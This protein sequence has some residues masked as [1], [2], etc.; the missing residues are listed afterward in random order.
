M[1]SPNAVSIEKLAQLRGVSRRSAYTA[2]SK[3]D[4]EPIEGSNLYDLDNPKNARWIEKRPHAGRAKDSSASD[5]RLS[6]EDQKLKADIALK[7]RQARKLDRQ[8]EVDMQRLIPS[9]IAAAWLGAY[10][11]GTRIHLLDL[12]GRLAPRLH[13]AALSGGSPEELRDMLASE[14]EDSLERALSMGEQAT[15]EVVAMHAEEEGDDEE[16]ATDES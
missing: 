1:S 5:P 16:L 6:L 9:D 13:A 3:N 11:S 7:H 8:H 15:R 12:P 14:I 10:G 4:I 2:K